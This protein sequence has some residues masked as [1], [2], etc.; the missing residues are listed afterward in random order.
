MGIYD[1]VIYQKGNP[2]Y[3]LARCKARNQNSDN[4]NGT[5]TR[6]NQ[7]EHHPAGNILTHSLDK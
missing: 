3:L 4:P 5:V 6:P 7:S 2:I 1:Y